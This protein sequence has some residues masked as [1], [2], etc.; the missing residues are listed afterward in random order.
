MKRRLR[1]AVR[2][3]R[4]WPGPSADVVIN[5][6]KVVFDADFEELLNDVRQAFVVIERR[7]GGR[8]DP[9]GT[10]SRSLKPEA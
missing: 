10:T 7:L 4:P 6:K 8:Q 5:P 2:L 1:E 9:A 3:I